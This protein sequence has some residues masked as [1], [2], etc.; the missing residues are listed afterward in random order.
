MSEEALSFVRRV[1]HAIRTLETVPKTKAM[2]VE[3]KL[4]IAGLTAEGIR[5][6]K[7][8]FEYFE[9]GEQSRAELWLLDVV[10]II[11][12][13]AW[14]VSNYCVISIDPSLSN[15]HAVIDLCN[16]RQFF[17]R[18]C[19]LVDGPDGPYSFIGLTSTQEMLEV[20]CC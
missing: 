20:P 1:W 17:F 9:Q 5:C 15:C 19:I 16:E 12:K 14:L 11:D 3:T 10:F 4:A 8:A 6:L 18:W 2:K 13:I 7:Q